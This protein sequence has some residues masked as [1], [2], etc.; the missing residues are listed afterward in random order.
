[1]NA[2]MPLRQL[3]AAV[4]L[5]ACATLPGP[6]AER[7]EEV[8]AAL[9]GQVVSLSVTYQGYVED[10]PWDKQNPALRESHAVV[11][12]GPLLLTTARYLFDATFIQ[13]TKRG[14]GERFPAHVVHIDPEIDLALVAVDDPAF[15]ADLQPARLAEHVPTSGLVLSARWSNRQLEVSNSRVSRV[16]VTD[17]T[18]GAVA[19]MK[20]YLR[21]DLVKG[22]WS[23]PVFDPTGRLLGLTFGQDEQQAAALPVEVLRAYIADARSGRD[24][25][26]F[27]ALGIGWQINRDI[28]LARHLG[29]AGPARGIVVRTVPWGATGSGVLE[30]RDILLELDGRPIDAEGYYE[31]PRYGR[32]RLT[33]LLVDGHRV[34]DV[35]PVRVLRGGRELELELPLHAYAQAS[36]LI[37]WQRAN[38]PPPYVI[39]GGFVFRELD[40]PYLRTWGNEWRKNIPLNLAT[41]L[42]LDDDAQQPDR[43]R[44]IL[45][46]GVLPDEYTIGYEDVAD[47]L[48]DAING[49]PIDSI[50]EVEEAFRH[51]VDGFHTVSFLPNGLRSEAVLDA[52]EFEA[53][54]TRILETYRIPERARLP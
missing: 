29:L 30:P 49:R 19:C 41:R 35:V 50:A 14:R 11:V 12:D 28:A 16:E 3:A 27:A 7:A 39:A 25:R 23:E 8:A 9:E 36:R 48:V 52:A 20:L 24:Y 54:T 34:G 51:P 18:Y 1:M 46:A 42:D 21:S 31:H 33:N 6:A 38:T 53:A 22:G 10:R 5:L 4:M 15:Y 32:L 45:L 47:L 44:L 13:A 40:S 43:S 17:S 2:H 26:G 37:P